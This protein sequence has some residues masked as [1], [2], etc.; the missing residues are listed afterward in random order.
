MP[1]RGGT[2]PYVM[3]V[4]QG[5]LPVGLALSNGA[6]TGMTRFPGTYQFTVAVTDSATP[7]AMVTQ[8][9]TLRVIIL[10]TDT[11]LSVDP[12]AMSLVAAGA[13][14]VQRGRIGVG[15]GASTWTGRPRAMPRG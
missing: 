6:L 13:Q 12:P 15:S 5:R 14:R 11:A 2:P 1:V 4:V 7:A 10:Q 8:A 3:R 9:M